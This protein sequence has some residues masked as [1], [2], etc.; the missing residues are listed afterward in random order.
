MNTRRLHT[1]SLIFW[2]TVLGGASLTLLLI[3]GLLFSADIAFTFGV[4]GLLPIGAA[5]GS[6]VLAHTQR[7]ELG[8]GLFLGVILG[9]VL[10]VVA[11]CAFAACYVATLSTT[12]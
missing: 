4:I 9:I 7:P 2:G 11:A 1:E 3:S 8:W 10:L 5:L 12:G 6:V